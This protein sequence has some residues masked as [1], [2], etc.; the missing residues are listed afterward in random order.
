MD[1]CKQL[2]TSLCKVISGTAYV[3]ISFLLSKTTPYGDWFIAQCFLS[4]S[5]T[6]FHHT[7]TVY[8]SFSTL[9]CL[10]FAIYCCIFITFYHFLS[11]LVIF[12]HVLSFFLFFYHLYYFSHT[13]ISTLSDNCFFA[14][15]FSHQHSYFLY[16]LICSII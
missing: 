5:Y 16:I 15:V 4:H 2:N 8:I 9:Y 3:F 12:S 7:Y 11:S 1:R 6:F 14:S 13:F 10:W